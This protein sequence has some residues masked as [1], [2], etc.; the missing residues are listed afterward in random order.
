MKDVKISSPCHVTTFFSSAALILTILI[1]A[2]PITAAQT[3]VFVP[4][5]TNG[6][7][8]SGIDECNPLV[9]ALTVDGPGTITITYV[10][11]IVTDVD[12]NIGPNGGPCPTGCA[13]LP[14]EEARGITGMN[15]QNLCALIGVFIPQDRAQHAGFKPIDGTKNLTRVGILPRGLFFVG[16]GKTFQV[17]EPGTLFLGINDN[18]V[19]DNGGGFNVTVSVQ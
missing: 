8:G 17:T 19:G 14:L 18:W 5:N 3:N 9:A 1:F 10:S 4:G 16:T 11:G 15:I 12:G 7:F 13:Q 2:A 6:C